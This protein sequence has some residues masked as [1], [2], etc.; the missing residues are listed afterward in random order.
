M[1]FLSRISLQLV[2]CLSFVIGANGGENKGEL[3]I[4]TLDFC[5]LVFLDLLDFFL[6]DFVLDFALLDSTSLDFALLESAWLESTLLDS[7]WLDFCV[8][9]C[10][11]GALDICG[12]L[13]W[14][15]CPTSANAMK[16]G[17]SP[18]AKI[19]FIIFRFYK[20]A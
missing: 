8:L 9:D 3:K 2:I 15:D 7:A 20:I 11:C 19:F 17:T 13:D 5:V 14:L 6:L 16:Q 12:A 10:T 1:R 18:Q 4:C